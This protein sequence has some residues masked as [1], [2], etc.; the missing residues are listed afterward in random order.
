MSDCAHPSI[1][2]WTYLE[3]DDAGKPASLWSCRECGHKF[4]PATEFERFAALAELV[5]E[6]LNADS[7]NVSKAWQE[8]AWAALREFA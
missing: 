6:I 8:R 5:R 2:T 1:T 3:G 4:Y 7:L